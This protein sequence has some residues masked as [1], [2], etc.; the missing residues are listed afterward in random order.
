MKIFFFFIC[1]IFFI[2]SRQQKSKYNLKN[3]SSSFSST[4]ELLNQDENNSDNE[5]NSNEVIELESE[6]IITQLRWTKKE[7]YDLNYLLGIFEG[8]ND[9]SFLD[10][11]PLAIIKGE[12]KVTNI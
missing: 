4:V 12:I 3:H 5:F 8:A 11:V 6:F 1:N 7:D 2:C 10:A 9:P